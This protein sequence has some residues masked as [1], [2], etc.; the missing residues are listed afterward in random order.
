MPYASNPIH[1]GRAARS[2]AV[3][4]KMRARHV[5][6]ALLA[7]L[8]ATAAGLGLVA[9][10]DAQAVTPVQ[11]GEFRDWGAFTYNGPR[12]K[13]CFAHTQPKSY[14]TEPAGRSRDPAHFFVTNRPGENVRG[15]VSVIVGFPHSEN[16]RARVAIGSNGFN[17]ITNNDDANVG[18]AWIEDQAQEAQLIQAMRAGVDMTVVSTSTRGTKVTDTYSLRGISAALDKI[19]AECG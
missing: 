13:V 5:R 14:V 9:K 1:K 18:G 6:N 7:G 3:R 16:E 4:A 10:A 17:L 15:E 12:G 19:N 2:E 8:L 11:V